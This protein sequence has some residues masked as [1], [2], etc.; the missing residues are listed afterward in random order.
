VA[1]SRAKDQMWVYHS[2]PREALTNTEDMRFQLLDYC[3]GV[4]NRPRN[5]ADASM[6][7]QVPEDVVVAPFDSL[8]EQRVFNRIAD[9]GYTVIP[10]FPALG[11]RIDLVIV[12]AKTRLAV[13]CDGDTWHGPS[14][15]EADLG[16]QR[17]LERCGWQFFRIRESVFYADMPGALQKLWDT[18]D[19]LD[20]RTADWVAAS[21]ND[22]GQDEPD[23]ST[24]E[25]V[26]AEED[27]PSDALNVDLAPT[28]ED[29]ASNP[30][31]ESSE[32]FD[33]V[34]SL[35]V[36]SV[37]PAAEP[38]SDA[39]A[40]PCDESLAV[41]VAETAVGGAEA[42]PV[43]AG[44]LLPYQAF[45]EALPDISETPLAAMV[46]NIV[47]IVERE[48]PIIGNRLHQVYVKSAG[49]TRVGRDIARQL[50]QAISLA[51]RRGLILSENPL[52]E[53]GVKPKTFRTA[54]QPSVSPRELGPR[55]LDAVPPA[56]LAQHLSDLSAGDAL[57]T[58]EALFRAVLD[59][60]GLKRLTENARALLTAAM[61]LVDSDGYRKQ[62]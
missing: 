29:R 37:D 49:G 34:E 6:P 33:V 21:D 4:V 26:D 47:R 44:V 15:Y 41:S 50:N 11:Y 24:A 30:V 22:S 17:E 13:E 55:T 5:D 2:V 52:N 45:E 54:A 56:E 39:E 16:R 25:A 59:L 19:E 31:A 35:S 1:A 28:D 42:V 20:I 48:G 3:Y 58:E 60:L 53:A 51:E 32:R 9:R 40:R 62:G 43:S 7:G 8:F 57:M 18:L 27:D 12:G 23:D 38:L 61:S 36:D 10:Q 14:Q 46:S